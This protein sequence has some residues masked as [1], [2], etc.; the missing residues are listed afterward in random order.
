MPRPPGSRRVFRLPWR[1]ARTVDADI[2]EELAFHLDMRTAEN[3]AIRG[4]DPTS[5]RAEALRQFGD[6]EDARAYI[7]AMDR[8]TETASRRRQLMDDLRQDLTHALRTLR[9]SPGFAAVAILALALGIGATTAIF[10]LI[11]AAL[12]RPLPVPHPEQLVGIGDPTR[13]NSAS[14]GSPRLDLISYPLYVDLRDGNKLVT[15]LLASGRGGLLDVVIADSGRPR[16]AGSG[17]AEHPR[18]RFVSG[19]Y[20]AV[21]GVPAVAGRTLTPQDDGAP[22]TGSVAVISHG[23]WRRRFNLDPGAVGRTISVNNAPV[24]IVGV[25]PPGFFGDVVGGSTDIWM[26][27]SMQPLVMRNSDWLRNRGTSWLLLMG[28]LAPGVTLAQAKAGFTVL[29]RQALSAGAQLP[30]SPE[31][32]ASLLREPVNIFAADKGFSSVRERF[33]APLAILMVA[34]GLVLL[35]V[36]ANVA[37]LM[38]ARAAARE[39]EMT[40]RLALGAGRLRLARQLLVESAVLGAAAGALGLLIAWWGS[41]LLLRLGSTG[42]TPIPLDAHL[43]LPVLG[44][45]TAL[46]LATA[47]LLGLVPAARATKVDLASTLRAQGRGALG[48]LLGGGSGRRLGL[49]KLLVIAQV[50]LSLVLLVGAGLLVRSTRN[51]QSADVGLARD[52]LL[53]IEVDTRAAGYMGE[54]LLQVTRQ[55]TERLAQIPG[56]TGVTFSEN[57]IFSGTESASTVQVDGFI[58]KA[59]EDSSAN[60]DQVGPAYVRTIGAR[61]LRG[62]DIEERDGPRAPRVALINEAMARFYFAGREPVGQ[63]LRLDTTR[64][65]IVGV[66]ADIRDHSLR[67]DP[68]RR[69]YLAF[70]QRTDSGGG[71]NFELRTAGDP[72]RLVGAARAAVRAVDP[73]LRVLD[74]EPLTELMR[75]SIAQERLLARLA[76]I[77]GGMALVLAA[78]GL[79]GVMTYTIVR[80]TREF[81]LRMALGARPGDVTRMVLRETMALFLIGAAVGIPAALGSVRLIKHQLVGVGVVDPLTIATALVVLGASA[82]LA[83][84]R[85]A[86]RAAHVAPQIALRQE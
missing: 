63:R 20:F 31:V 7:R 29:T 32:S 86:S 58:A 69:F 57:G 30:G 14:L 35:I 27:L 64:V 43:D 28:R 36:C 15:G 66:V 3:V 78:L 18:G 84:Y 62:R 77:A 5:A 8:Y 39:T 45:T 56:V 17:E 81:G 44:F 1:S 72:A 74:A 48:G 6:L 49:G 12:L 11:N 10:T 19:N 79:Y 2:D 40:V 22:G 53:M 68:P 46:S 70:N 23:Y 55:L 54:P 47:T 38:L 76:G 4:L 67:D 80:R 25:T 16:G 61:L 37:N 33:R 13:V 52:Q 83:G 24:T 42:D 41:A 82:A 60:F 50:A 85:P 75:Q 65:E 26:P 51:L 34:T 21:L 71:V 59:E 9:R 73:G